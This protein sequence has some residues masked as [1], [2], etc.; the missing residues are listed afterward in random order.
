ADAPVVDSPDTLG[1][2]SGCAAAGAAAAMPTTA[3]TRPSTTPGTPAN[4]PVERVPVPG[5]PVRVP[6]P[7]IT[8]QD[9]TTYHRVPTTPVP[10]APRPGSPTSKRLGSH[11]TATAAAAQLGTTGPAR[12]VTT[13]GRTTTP[14]PSPT[15]PGCCPQ[16]GKPATPDPPT[17]WW[18]S[19]D[20]TTTRIPAT[21]ANVRWPGEHPTEVVD[22]TDHRSSDRRCDHR[23]HR[24]GQYDRVHQQW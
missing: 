22:R 12:A 17:A 16:R 13:T 24:T 9:R 23:D 18:P 20:T 5:P 8:K 7:T 10:H 14:A 21:S 11:D 19:A 3:S 4:R 2:P 1:P 6:H 15:A